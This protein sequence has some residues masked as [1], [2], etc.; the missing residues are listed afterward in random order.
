MSQVLARGYGPNSDGV[1]VATQA[2]VLALPVADEFNPGRELLDLQCSALGVCRAP[3][4]VLASA[5][6]PGA[7]ACCS[8]HEGGRAKQTPG[9]PP[10]VNSTPASSNARFNALIVTRRG[11]VTT[12]VSN[13]WIEFLATSDAF[14]RSARV[15]LRRPRAALHCSFVT[16][17]DDITRNSALRAG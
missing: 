12:P 9:L 2:T 10:F 6:T 7:R 15:Q 17:S 1:V 4:H 13:N 8:R 11:C 14:A 5:C 3:R 16:D